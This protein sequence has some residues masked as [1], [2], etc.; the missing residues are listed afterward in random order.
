MKAFLKRILV[1][2]YRIMAHILPVNRKKIMFMSNMG[3]NYSGN[4]RALYEKSKEDP[5]YSDMKKLWAFNA[6]YEKKIK[7]KGAEAPKAL[8]VRYGSPSYYFHMATAGVW[9]FDTRQ[10]PYLIK[11]KG[12]LYL[13][14][15]HGTPLKKL[16]L[17]LE[18][19]NMAGEKRDL[20]GYRAAFTDE[21]E[22]WDY[23]IVQNDF[24]E[25]V[26]PKCFG[27]KHEVLKT[28]YP[29]NDRLAE[30]SLNNKD[31]YGNGKSESKKK[32]LLFAPTWR[33]D[34]Y[35]EGGFY[36]CPKRPDFLKLE[37]L[38][39]DR[40][41][42]ILK[43]HYLVRLK[44]GDIPESCIKSGFVRICGNETDIADLYLKADGLITDYSSVFFDYSVLMRPVFFFCFD[45]E[46][47]RNEL[48]GFYLDLEEIAPGPISDTE[49]KLAKDIEEAFKNGNRDYIKKLSQFR[50]E[51][52]KYDDGKASER[53]LDVLAKRLQL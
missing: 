36:S 26:L 16:G 15:W 32:V 41:R 44:K 19:L 40:Y 31:P 22:K 34:E 3:R 48:R 1:G 12:A 9:I 47:Y 27:F 20:A 8:R 46:K 21:A 43:L 29:R 7:D 49:E 30:E 28:G 5:R 25:K 17:D 39:S 23:L 42:I 33:D 45:L 24:S 38:L 35:Q 13:M 50:D 2:I 11:R 37:K 6:D 10:E 18:N 4:V 53:I 52:N 14:T 51:Y